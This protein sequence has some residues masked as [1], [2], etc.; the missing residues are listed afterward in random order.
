MNYNCL[1]RRLT[2]RGIYSDDSLKL[3]CKNVNLT[4]LGEAIRTG[5]VGRVEVLVDKFGLEALDASFSF[6]VTVD[7]IVEGKDSSRSSSYQNE[8]ATLEVTSLQLAILSA[9]NG[10]VQIL[11][12]SAVKS[13]SGQ[14][15][16]V[17][18]LLE[19]TTTL[20]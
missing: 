15:G 17:K 11:L 6:R 5:D 4:S 8:T 13:Q 16:I 2:K 19:A 18:H 3:T 14:E 9:Q 7:K 12:E 1:T 10:V 20:R